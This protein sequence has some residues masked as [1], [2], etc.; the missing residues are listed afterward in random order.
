[1][2]SEAG[3]HAGRVLAVALGRQGHDVLI[4][5]ALLEAATSRGARA[6]LA[7]VP[8]RLDEAFTVADANANARVSTT[9]H[10]AGLPLHRLEGGITQLIAKRCRCAQ[11][12]VT[13]PTVTLR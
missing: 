6:L 4:D 9:L 5:A 7:A 3:D 8:T 12:T 13:Q 1:M 11:P 10:G 2:D